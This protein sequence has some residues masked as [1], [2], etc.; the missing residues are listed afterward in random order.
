MVVAQEKRAKLFDA[1]LW[2]FKNKQH[3]FSNDP[4]VTDLVKQMQEKLDIAYQLDKLVVGTRRK[5]IPAATSNSL[6][7]KLALAKHASL[8]GQKVAA[9]A[10]YNRN[11]GLL[12]ETNF[13][14][15][16]LMQMSDNSLRN[17]SLRILQS[18]EANFA[19]L[20][21]YRLIP[22]MLDDLRAAIQDFTGKQSGIEKTDTVVEEPVVTKSNT[23]QYLNAI[24][25]LL[26]QLDVYLKQFEKKH[27]EFYQNY[28]TF[29]FS[30]LSA[31]DF[32]H[33]R[34]GTFDAK[35]GERIGGVLV[36]ITRPDQKNEAIS[37]FSKPTR[38][39]LFKGISVGQWII[40]AEMS[41]YAPVSVPIN[42]QHCFDGVVSLV[43]EPR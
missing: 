24:E 42:L 5:Q 30:S 4:V 3:P 7:Q 26:I 32:V 16:K 27:I 1:V 22:Q 6:M 21:E 25:D 34:I 14:E 28:R 43:L 2:L 15:G 17:T 29:R 35:T 31:T 9:Y 36:K 19:A 38:N 18:A 33:V 37:R 40:S 23:L 20:E 11:F 41:S 8:V 10:T 12:H 39:M 13:F